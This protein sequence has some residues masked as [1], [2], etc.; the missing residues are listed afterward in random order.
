LEKENKPSEVDEPRALDEVLLQPVEGKSNPPE[1]NEPD[2]GF[3]DAKS[4]PSV[5]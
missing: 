4:D 2:A 5:D 1:P 3:V